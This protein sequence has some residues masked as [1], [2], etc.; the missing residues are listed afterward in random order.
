MKIAV[1]ADIHGNYIALKTCVEYILERGI[2][3][4]IFLGDYLGD[5]PYVHETMQYLYELNKT[6]DCYF[7]KGNK[8]D[9][10]LN[11]DPAWKAPSSTTG[12]LAYTYQQL[13]PE[14]FSFFQKLQIS[15]ILTLEQRRPVLICHGSPDQVNEKMLPDNERTLEIL[16]HSPVHLILCGH[17]H[18]QRVISAGQTIAV[19]PGSV[20]MSLNGHGKAQFAI[21]NDNSSD[22][23]YELVSLAYDVE[24]TIRA[25]HEKGLSKAAPFWCKVTEYVLRTGE[26]SHGTVL[27]K[28]MALCREELGECHW[29]D[30]PERFWEMAVQEL[31]K[32]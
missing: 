23:D 18:V 28:A 22:W 15:Q 17:T 13:T 2:T 25:L 5:L 7:I 4:F 9:Y 12:C 8:E 32:R 6:Y 24:Q 20:G 31:I 1:L 26:I 11:F 10:W 19:N 16:R 14:D 21:L 30:I 29:P 27:G 3:T